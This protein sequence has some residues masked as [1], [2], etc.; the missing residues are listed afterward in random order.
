ME[1]T[2][3]SEKLLTYLTNKYSSLNDNNAKAQQMYDLIMQSYNKTK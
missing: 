3:T 1:N 2:F